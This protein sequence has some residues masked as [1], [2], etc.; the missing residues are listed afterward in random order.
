VIGEVL[1]GCTQ[2]RVLLPP[3]PKTLCPHLFAVARRAPVPRFTLHPLPFLCCF[4]VLRPQNPVH[5]SFVRPLQRQLFSPNP[6]TS[7]YYLSLTVFARCSPCPLSSQIVLTILY[8]ADHTLTIYSTM[9]CAYIRMLLLPTIP[10]AIEYLTFPLYSLDFH[11]RLQ[12]TNMY[13]MYVD[14]LHDLLILAI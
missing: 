3:S 7:F 8:Q 1:H 14:E 11:L 6:L 9:S 4:E 5:I 13:E 10:I 2:T 12:A